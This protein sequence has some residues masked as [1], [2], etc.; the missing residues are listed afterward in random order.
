[1]PWCKLESNLPRHRKIIRLA[2]MLGVSR[3]Q[4][5]GLVVNLWCAVLD[6]AP[7][8]DI[9][10]WTDE[11]IAEYCG[12]DGDVTVMSQC[13]TRSGFVDH[14]DSTKKIHGWMERQGSYRHAIKVRNWRRRKEK[15]QGNSDVT[16]TSPW[17][18]CD[19]ERRGEENTLTH[20]S[21]ETRGRKK[22][23][24][25]SPPGW[26][27]RSWSGFVGEVKR[28]IEGTRKVA[29][30]CQSRKQADACAGKIAKA[31][32]ENMVTRDEFRRAVRFHERRTYDGRPYGQTWAA[33]AAKFDSVVAMI[34]R[35]DATSTAPKSVD[36]VA[37]ALGGS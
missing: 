9:S 30:T 2:K 22:A 12:W 11:E 3:V 29:L 5:V 19:V 28:I 27:S 17:D 20:A 35:E 36:V 31:V 15:D 33:L 14:T 37:R 32:R 13:I 34:R 4:A 26:D 25:V 21:R 16:V 8:G 10:D 1:M 6:H 18:H 23:T 7:D 24:F